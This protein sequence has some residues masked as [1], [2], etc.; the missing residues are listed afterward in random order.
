MKDPRG[1][2]GITPPFLQNSALD[3]GVW[4]A[5][6]AGC[7]SPGTHFIGGGLGPKA[8]LKGQGSS[9]P[10]LKFELHCLLHV[11]SRYALVIK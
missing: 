11:A 7:F 6:L 10:P 4:L 2:R 3:V 5:P 1:S 8:G 9:R